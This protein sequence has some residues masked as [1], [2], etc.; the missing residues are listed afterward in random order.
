MLEKCLYLEYTFRMENKKNQNWIKIIEKYDEDFK[1]SDYTPQELEEL[2][3]CFKNANEQF[4]EKYFA[5]Y[6]DIK[7]HTRK[8]Q[9]W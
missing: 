3:D 6:D 4:K 1:F 5:F 9:D 7:S 2:I 8:K